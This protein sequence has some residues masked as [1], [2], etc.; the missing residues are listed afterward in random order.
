M[1]VIIQYELNKSTLNNL[2]MPEC[3]DDL[4]VKYQ[5]FVAALIKI[6]AYSFLLFEI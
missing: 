2:L 4:Q 5:T 1:I 3:T 6:E